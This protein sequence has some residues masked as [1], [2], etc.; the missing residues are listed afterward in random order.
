[1]SFF[2]LTQLGVQ[3]PIKIAVKGSESCNIP[4]QTKPVEALKTP[5]CSTPSPAFHDED[6]KG[7]KYFSEAQGSYVKYTERLTKHQRTKND[8]NEIYSKPITS[9]QEYGWWRQDG[10]PKTL[11]WTEIQKFSRVNSEMTRFVDEMTLTN[12]HFTLF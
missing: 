1:M 7:A 12:K 5:T 4:D 11:P 6:L 8:P 2:N 3:D 9:S 10:A